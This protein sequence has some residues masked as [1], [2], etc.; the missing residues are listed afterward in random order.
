MDAP[1]AGPTAARDR[2]LFA[3]GDEPRCSHL[4]Q[5]DTTA[6]VVE[7]RKD[8]YGPWSGH[9]APVHPPSGKTFSL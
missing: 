4:D 7:H 1:G 5:E 3:P 8:F 2:T 9:A 6:A